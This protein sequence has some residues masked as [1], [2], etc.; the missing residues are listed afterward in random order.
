MKKRIFLLTLVLFLTG[1]MVKEEAIDITVFHNTLASTYSGRVKQK[2]PNGNGQAILENNA[3]VEGEFEEGIFISGEASQVPYSLTN[4]T[5][6]I[7]GAYTGNVSNQLPNGEGSF[8]ADAFSYQGSF[9]D[10]AIEKGTLSASSFHIDT[11][12]E[13]LE[14]NYN[15]DVLKGLAEGN[16]TFT[17]QENNTPIEISGTFTNN[18]FDGLLTK[19][20]HYSNATK[21]YPVYYQKG[22]QLQTAVSMIAYLEGMRNTSYRLSEA[23]S[24]FISEH[25]A[26]FE[27]EKKELD[28]SDEVNSS[29]SYEQFNETDA[30]NFIRIQNATI[31][32]IQRYQPYEEANTVTSMIVQNAD[33]WYHL[34]FAY[35]VDEVHRDDYVDI[36]A[37]PLCRSTLTAPEQDYPAIDAVGAFVLQH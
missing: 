16:G 17:Y 14:G 3:M 32:S 15:G 26:L 28:S 19:T 24:T 9:V 33:G 21:S 5:Q 2:L 35:S 20:I 7:K 8:E 4:N 23:Q 22:W 11:P 34:V 29:F 30:P 18:M 25:A 27:G 6:T 36:Y 13:V 31:K 10:G 1:C 37:L 12:F